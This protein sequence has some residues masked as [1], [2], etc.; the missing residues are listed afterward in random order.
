MTSD[1]TAT[2]KFLSYVLRHHPATIEVVLDGSGWIG[3]DT[4]LAAAA[5]MD[6]RSTA[7][8]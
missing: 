6:T 7:T 5:G 1:P 4:L 3:V 8:C 2:S